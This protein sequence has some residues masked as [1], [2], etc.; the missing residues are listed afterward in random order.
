MPFKA[1]RSL[2]RH[3]DFVLPT[4]LQPLCLLCDFGEKP[5]P[6]LLGLCVVLDHVNEAVDL[7]GDGV[8]GCGE[9]SI[10]FA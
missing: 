1:V 4:Q 7:G 9:D 10:E 2:R 3:S 5:E 8:H 6:G